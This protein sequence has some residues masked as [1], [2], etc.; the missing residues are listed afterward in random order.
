MSAKDAA[1]SLDTD[2]LV[3]IR[4]LYKHSVDRKDAL[5]SKILASWGPDAEMHLK[6]SGLPEYRLAA[7]SPIAERYSMT[8]ADKLMANIA[9]ARLRTRMGSGLNVLKQFCWPEP[10]K[11]NIFTPQCTRHGQC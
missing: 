8:V 6:I 11:L 4:K 7:I 1:D 10:Q 5:I 9:T 3:A 2:Q